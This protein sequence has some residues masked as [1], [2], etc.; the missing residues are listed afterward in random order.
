M[1]FGALRA[2]REFKL[3]VPED[4]AVIGFDYQPMAGWHAFE[5]TA[6]G[7]DPNALARLATGKILDALEH[8]ELAPKSFHIQPQLVIRRTTP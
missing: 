8:D 4:F 1:A 3:S 6:I 2:A 5:L 7:Y